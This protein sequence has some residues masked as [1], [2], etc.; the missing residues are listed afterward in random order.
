MAG[1]PNRPLPLMQ[2]RFEAMAAPTECHVIP[3]SA[4]R[5]LPHRRRPS[6]RFP[7]RVDGASPYCRGHLTGSGGM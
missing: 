3:V 4:G 6:R 2:S 7:G 1:I 5:R